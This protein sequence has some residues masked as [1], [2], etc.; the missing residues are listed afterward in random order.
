MLPGDPP[1]PFPDLQLERLE[2]LSPAAPAGFLRLVRER[3]Q[4][5]ASDGHVS[6][7]FVYDRIDRTGIDA[8]VIAAFFFESGIPHVYLRSALR[9]PLYFRDP[10]RSPQP[11]S[12]L[13]ALWELPAGLIDVGEQSAA[14]VHVA[15]A[16]E[17][18]EELGFSVAPAAIVRLGHSVLPCPGV[19][20]ER[21]YF[22]AVQV[23]PARRE[24]PTLDGSELE[25]E[26]RVATVS[27][28]QA[29]AWI[30]AGQL[31]DAKTELGLRRLAEHLQ[32]GA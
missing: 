8:V 10:K 7:P 15:A 26:G 18:Q 20:A 6:R 32:A 21:Q 11:E 22:T 31:E 30:R 14:G 24:Q 29:L 23:D 5:R 12:G 13:G 9:P 4:V 17:L 2:D 28:E 19:I 27:L 16:R 25:R 1:W 3:L